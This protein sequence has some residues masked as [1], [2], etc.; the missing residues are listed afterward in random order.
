[1]SN[2]RRWFKMREKLWNDADFALELVEICKKNGWIRTAR[3]ER[4]AAQLFFNRSVLEEKDTKMWT[5]VEKVNLAGD[6]VALEEEKMAFVKQKYRD[7]K[8]KRDKKR[9]GPAVVSDEEREAAI[10]QIYGM[11]S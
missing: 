4:A 2:F 10:R 6:K 11:S 1:V 8:T 9:L 5:L 3:D 7:K